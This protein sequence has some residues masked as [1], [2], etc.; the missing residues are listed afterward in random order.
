VERV[1]LAELRA[2]GSHAAGVDLEA[3]RDRL[4]AT[5]D[6]RIAAGVRAQERRL[7]ALMVLGAGALAL[8]AS[9][10]IARLPI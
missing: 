9:L 3:V 6:G 7:S 2:G 1:T 4:A 8:V 10:A 5:I